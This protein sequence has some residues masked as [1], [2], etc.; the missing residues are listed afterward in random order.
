MDKASEKELG[1]EMALLDRF[2][3]QRLPRILK[4]LD[5][6]ESGKLLQDSEL[7]FLEEVLETCRQLGGFVQQYPHYGEIYNQAIGLYHE[8]TTKALENER[9]LRKIG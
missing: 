6:V 8:V 4:M 2:T 9:K 5:E 1:I 3:E 7:Q